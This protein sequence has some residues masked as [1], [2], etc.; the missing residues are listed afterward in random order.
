MQWLLGQWQSLVP[1]GDSLGL[2]PNPRGSG[3]I[4]CWRQHLS[5]GALRLQT[6]LFC[7]LSNIS[8]QSYARHKSP[9]LP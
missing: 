3:G 6:E 5:L 8:G 4:L 2:D 1:S 7:F 9:C